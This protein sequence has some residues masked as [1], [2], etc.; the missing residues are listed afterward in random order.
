[1]VKNL[2][3]N[4]EILSEEHDE[5]DLD[6]SQSVRMIDP[7]DGTKDF[8]FGSHGGEK[9]AKIQG[10]SF[11]GSI[12]IDRAVREGGDSGTPCILTHPDSATSKAIKQAAT[13]LAR[14]VSITNAR[15]TE[16]LS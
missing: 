15:Q 11:L 2:F 8:I 12:P 6:Y 10:I 5:K 1:M 9:F 4:D 3:P 13:E 7:L 14:Q 16:E